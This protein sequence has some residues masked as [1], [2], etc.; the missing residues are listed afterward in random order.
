[1]KCLNWRDEGFDLII[2]IKTSKLKLCSNRT[3]KKKIFMPTIGFNL[4]QI[5]ILLCIQRND[6]MIQIDLLQTIPGRNNNATTVDLFLYWDIPSCFFFSC[7]EG[8]VRAVCRR[9]PLV[10][11]LLRLVFYVFFCVFCPLVHCMDT[12][13]R[14]KKKNGRR[15]VSCNKNPYLIWPI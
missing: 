5:W 14:E 6:E 11:F 10:C 3:V 4:R 1:M 2:F 8:E 12:K 15:Q 7:Q 13:V 9:S